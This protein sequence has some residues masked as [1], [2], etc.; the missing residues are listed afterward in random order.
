MNSLS[1]LQQIL[2]AG[3][4]V[5]I[6]A[7]FSS[8]ETAMMS[9][10]R[11]RA[12]HRARGG[13]KGATMAVRLLKNPKKLIGV[14]LIGNNLVNLLASALVTLAA[15]N[16]WG[17]ES[18][19]LA[20][21]ALTLVI[22]IF[23]EVTPKTLAALRPEWLAY[24]MAYPLRFLLW[25]LYPLVWLVN[26]ASDFFLFPLRRLN[27]DDEHAL[28]QDELRTL[29][30]DTGDLIPDQYQKMLLNILDLD[31]LVVRDIM[32]PRHQVQ[33]IDMEKGMDHFMQLIHEVPFTELPVYREDLD[34]MRGVLHG[35]DLAAFVVQGEYTES[36][37][38]TYL[39]SPYFV[40]DTTP[41]HQQLLQFQSEQRRMGL[42]VDEYGDIQG[43]VTL[44]DILEEIVGE[45]DPENS[46]AVGIRPQ[47]DGSCFVNGSVPV[48]EINRAMEW[49]LPT[50]GPVTM[51]GLVIE[52]LGMIPEHNLCLWLEDYRIEVTSVQHNMVRG[53][54]VWRVA[55]EPTN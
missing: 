32:I 19:V 6:S 7:F 47:K 21:L 51:S 26:K 38:A 50:Q 53:M 12:N 27:A 11:Y 55:A 28:S 8:S 48:R 49:E 4:L 35:R 37:L 46:R 3:L 44:E 43:L 20:T 25:L 36:N 13:H 34:N 5:L 18:V 24:P 15:V 23:A 1:P 16:L 22:L 33:G 31:R 30:R 2:L 54:K 14:L 29:V 45:I 41:L 17:D 42:V 9:L 10:N 40:P 52:E 39:K